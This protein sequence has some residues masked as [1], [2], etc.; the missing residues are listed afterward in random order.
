[1]LHVS[2]QYALEHYNKYFVSD[3][4]RQ[5]LHGPEALSSS[6]ITYY[7]DNRCFGILKWAS[8]RGDTLAVLQLRSLY[9]PIS[10]I[11]LCAT[12]RHPSVLQLLLCQRDGRCS[13]PDMFS[14]PEY[15]NT[16]V[17]DAF[18]RCN[19][20]C[21]TEKLSPVT[22]LVLWSFGQTLRCYPPLQ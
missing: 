18:L 9:G 11:R 22:S 21:A 3:M 17:P 16:L 14:D 1:M 5:Q 20:Y 15:A 7:A 6:L 12:A 2:L 19:E 4:A 10:R 8:C 13:P